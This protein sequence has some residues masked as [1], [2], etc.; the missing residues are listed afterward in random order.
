MATRIGKDG[1]IIRDNSDQFRSNSWTPPPIQRHSNNSDKPCLIFYIITLVISAVVAWILSG[2][3]SVL[4]FNPNN[5]AGWFS[6][7]TAFIKNFSPYV[8][9]FAG[10]GGCFWYNIKHSFYFG[11]SEVLLSALSAIVACLIA[12]VALFLLALTIKIIVIII[13]VIVALTI[14]IGS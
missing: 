3:V 14:F 8:I 7:I 12:G 10:I 9:F 6:G 13:I 4:I 1:T 5:T 11:F 2:L